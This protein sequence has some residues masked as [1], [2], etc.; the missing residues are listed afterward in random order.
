MRRATR[1]AAKLAEEQRMHSFRIHV[2][3]SV[4]WTLRHDHL[5]GKPK[6]TGKGS[7]GSTSG[8]PAS[9]RQLRSRTHAIAHREL[10]EKAERLR[11]LFAVR[12]WT[13]LAP[14]PT[15]PSVARCL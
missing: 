3:G 12:R 5:P 4:T 2:D 8:E 6:P 13:R 7:T 11:R 9:Q 14:Q 15:P 1:R 10:Q